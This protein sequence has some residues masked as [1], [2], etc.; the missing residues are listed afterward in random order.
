MSEEKGLFAG[1]FDFGFQ[2][3]LTPRIVKLLYIIALLAGGITVVALVVTGMQQSPAQ[4]LLML[5]SGVVGLF[6]WILCT[7]LGLEVILVILRLAGNIER[8][9]RA[10]N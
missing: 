1:L 2:Q 10:N 9:T 3:T 6:I 5:V 4:G 8:V 7:R